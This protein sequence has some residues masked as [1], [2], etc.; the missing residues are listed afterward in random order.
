MPRWCCFALRASVADR[1]MPTTMHCHL[2]SDC[3][4]HG[5]LAPR[6]ADFEWD[7]LFRFTIDFYFWWDFDAR[8]LRQ[9]IY[10]PVIPGTPRRECEAAES[11]SVMSIIIKKAATTQSIPI[12]GKWSLPEW[13][14]Q[15]SS[16][17]SRRID[18][19]Y[20]MMSGARN[21]MPH[22]P[23][24][25]VVGN[26]PDYIADAKAA[27]TSRRAIESFKERR[28]IIDGR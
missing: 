26:A 7:I 21:L 6:R 23:D 4:R 1:L 24:S 2:V 11:I 10:G 19:Y 16:R 8:L 14:A 15:T 25:P 22:R 28:S 17:A 18:W 12:L 9:L 3:W 13:A 5:F 27:R 20:K